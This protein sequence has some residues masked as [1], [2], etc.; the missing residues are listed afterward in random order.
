MDRSASWLICVWAQPGIGAFHCEDSGFL[1]VLFLQEEDLGGHRH[2]RPG[3]RLRP[4][5]LH[6][7]APGRHLLQAPQPDPGVDGRRAH[8]P[9]QGEHR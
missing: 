7:Q 3:H 8:E 9:V 6:G 1:I 2:P 5:H 4:L